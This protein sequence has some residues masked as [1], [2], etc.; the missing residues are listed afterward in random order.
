VNVI[1]RWREIIQEIKTT[2]H[3]HKGLD[4]TMKSQYNRREQIAAL[5]VIAEVLQGA[6]KED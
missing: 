2:T 6:S 3:S 4:G 1:K 5:L